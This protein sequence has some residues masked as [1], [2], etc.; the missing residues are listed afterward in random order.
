MTV[1]GSHS[2]PQRIPVH[3]HRLGTFGGPGAPEHPDQRLAYKGTR[4]HALITGGV[5]RYPSTGNHLSVGR[6][7]PSVFS[8]SIRTRPWCLSDGAAAIHESAL[9]PRVSQLQGRPDE[10]STVV[11]RGFARF[12]PGDPTQPRGVPRAPPRWRSAFELGDALLVPSGLPAS[13]FPPAQNFA[14]EA[15]NHV[16]SGLARQE[17][18]EFLL[19]CLWRRRGS[20]GPR[21]ARFERGA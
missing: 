7:R 13:E 5:A 12:A 16:D 14:I 2:R 10:P 20:P 4:Y 21:V 15:A 9:T 1:R 8:F 6:P 17:L 19:E 3:E 11:P 18:L